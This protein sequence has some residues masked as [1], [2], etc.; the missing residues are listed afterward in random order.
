MSSSSFSLRRNDKVIFPI[1]SRS[2]IVYSCVRKDDSS[3]NCF[4]SFLSSIETP[5]P[6]PLF[7]DS[8]PP[9]SHSYLSGKEYRR[10]KDEPGNSSYGL[11]LCFYFDITFLFIALLQPPRYPSVGHENQSVTQSSRATKQTT[12][13]S[14]FEHGRCGW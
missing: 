1:P 2:V 12:G 6:R 4:S 7:P 8:R 5:D 10:E 3:V 11:E 9:P 13:Q 14:S